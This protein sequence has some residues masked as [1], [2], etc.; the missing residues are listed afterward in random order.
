MLPDDCCH[1]VAEEISSPIAAHILDFYYG[2]GLG[3]DLFAAVTAT[4]GPFPATDD[5]VSSSTATTPPICGYSE[6]TAA[7]GGATAYTPLTSFDTTL[8]ALL[9]EEQHHGL[10]AGFLPQIDGLSE[11]AAYY[12]T[13][14]DEASIGQFDQMG[15]PETLDEQVP[16]PVQMSSSASALMPLATDYDEC[17]MAAVAAGGFMGLD[18]AMYQQTG[19]VLPGC[20]AD[21]SQQEFFSSAGSNSMVMIGEYQKM[22]EGEGLTTTYD[23]TDSMQGTF[24]TNAE[25]QVGGNNQ[26]LINGCN[27]NPATLPPTELSVLEDSTFK[28]VRLSP[29]E[30]KEKIH[31]YIKK[32]NERNFRKKIKYACRKTLA[33]SRP[34]VRGR[35]A[36][37]DELCEAAQS[38]SQS[39]EHYEQTDHMKEEDML[40]TSDILAQL[41]GLNPYNYKYKSTIE[42]WI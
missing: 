30:R 16:P 4:S 20:S 23:D 21:A 39:H 14:T 10:D 34:R 11:V 32:R 40:D 15:L 28:V 31:R 8:T 9:E 36:K 18:G 27:G 13:A 17:F 33:D 7:A 29:E 37:N 19:A 38:G 41:N 25:M 35:F 12:P 42:S 26:H 5:D 24:N 22:M 6:D 1:I 3:D 2:D